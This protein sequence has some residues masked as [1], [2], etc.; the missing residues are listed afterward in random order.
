[1]AANYDWSIP[2][3]SQLNRLPIYLDQR[4]RLSP[5]EAAREEV[6]LLQEGFEGDFLFDEAAN[7]AFFKKN[8]SQYDIIH[9]AMH[10]L[11]DS[12]N[13]MLSSMAFTEN[14]DS[15]EN[16]FLQAH[17]ISKMKLNASLVVLSACETGYGKFEKGNGIASLAR[18]FA[19][20]GVP[21][22]VVSLWQ[23]NDQVTGHIMTQFYDNLTTGMT[24]DEALQDAKLRYVGLAEGLAAHP[25]YWSP[26]IMVGNTQAISL[27]KKT[28]SLPW[29]IGI[30]AVLILLLG[31][32][33]WYKRKEKSTD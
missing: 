4:K 21:A 24:K 10:G 31:A 22:M 1:M 28:V 9:L 12:R 6:V 8:A 30:G 26:F 23:V 17:E 3:N 32:F 29:I 2:K 20:A 18:S 16:N 15:V 27:T 13:P 7:E 11:L 25:A 33:V 19:Y 5:L 14:G